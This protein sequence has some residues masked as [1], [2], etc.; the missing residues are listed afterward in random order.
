[1]QIPNKQILPLTYTIAIKSPILLYSP[2]KTP[3]KIIFSITA[4]SLPIILKNTSFKN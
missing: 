1:M 4:M 2:V 3:E